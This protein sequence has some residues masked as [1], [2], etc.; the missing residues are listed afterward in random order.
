[1]KTKTDGTVEDLTHN[2][3]GETMWVELERG[4]GIPII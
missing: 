2:G 1:M 3:G 4:K